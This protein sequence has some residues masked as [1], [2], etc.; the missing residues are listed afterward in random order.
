MAKQ[1]DLPGKAKAYTAKCL[2]LANSPQLVVSDNDQSKHEQDR[3]PKRLLPPIA[4][5][6]P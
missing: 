5:F 6:Q 1:P 2:A 3:L 4:T